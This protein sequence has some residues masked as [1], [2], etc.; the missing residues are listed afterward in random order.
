MRAI[1]VEDHA[2]LA[3]M[4]Q[5]CLQH[6]GYV[7]NEDDILASGAE[8]LITLAKEPPPELLIIDWCLEG[9]W[10]GIDVMCAVR[11]AGIRGETPAIVITSGLHRPTEGVMRMIR[12]H[13][14]VFLAKPYSD[15]Q[16]R[17]AVAEAVSASTDWPIQTLRDE[18]LPSISG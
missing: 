9:E 15:Q 12:E 3:A 6:F 16:L 5:R 4:T 1:I 10:D 13:N 17:V 7:V 14:A 8:V 2:I 18:D 11:G